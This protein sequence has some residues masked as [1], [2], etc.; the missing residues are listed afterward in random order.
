V[1]RNATDDAS[2]PTIRIAKFEMALCRCMEAVLLFVC[3]EPLIERDRREAR[4]M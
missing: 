2:E 4:L 1:E 3:G